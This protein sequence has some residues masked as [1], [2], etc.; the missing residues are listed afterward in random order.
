MLFQININFINQLRDYYKWI[1]TSKKNTI[2]ITI[3]NIFKNK[4]LIVSG[5]KIKKYIYKTIASGEDF[6]VV[7]YAKNVVFVL[8]RKSSKSIE[9]F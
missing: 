6:C 7:N 2:F 5:E 4:H 8:L 1:A 9:F 3:S